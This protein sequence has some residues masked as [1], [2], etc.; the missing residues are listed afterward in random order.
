MHR[1]WHYYEEA[2]SKCNNKNQLVFLRT[3]SP[4]DLLVICDG[5]YMLHTH[6]FLSKSLVLY[7]LSDSPNEE[8]CLRLFD[9]ANEV[10]VDCN[11]ESSFVCGYYS[12]R[13]GPQLTWQRISGSVGDQVTG[14]ATDCHKTTTG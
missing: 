5:V 14:P 4:R 13:L 7:S 1:S 10:K 2:A 3:A 11:F 6:M 9:A 8:W 12:D